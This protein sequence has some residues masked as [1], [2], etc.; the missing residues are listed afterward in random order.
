MPPSC[1]IKQYSTVTKTFLSIFA[2]KRRQNMWLWFQKQDFWGD[3][4]FRSELF[5]WTFTWWES[6]S[7][8]SSLLTVMLNRTHGVWSLNSYCTVCTAEALVAC[9]CHRPPWP[10]HVFTQTSPFFC[11][12]M[13]C[14]K[15]DSTQS[16]KENQTQVSGT[17]RLNM[18]VLV[19]VSH[20]Q[21]NS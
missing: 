1:R 14:N 10:S 9:W 3:T 6:C 8:V 11:P 20:E 16:N 5:D 12:Q 4:G 15:G 21:S 2:K 13:S 18:L 7:S 17:L 19:C